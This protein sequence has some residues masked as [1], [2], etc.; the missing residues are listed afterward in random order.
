MMFR[1][2]MLHLVSMRR[3]ALRPSDINEDVIPRLVR[4]LG[5]I[6]NGLQL[7]LGMNKPS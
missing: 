3:D 5:D 2:R 6:V 7:R 1:Q 4:R